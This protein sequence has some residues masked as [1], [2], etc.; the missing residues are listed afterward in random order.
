MSPFYFIVIFIDMK[1]RLIIT[2][3][4]LERLKKVITESTAHS[5]VVKQM[6]NELDNNYAPI[7]KFVREGGEYFEKAMIMIKA[8]EELI[9]PKAIFEYLK[10]KYKTGDDFT[11]QV[12]N[13][14]V[15]G[16][17]TDDYRLSKNVPMN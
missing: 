14:W 13:D 17:I 11:K 6:K 3:S 5:S 7:E 16:K 10:S 2:E 4:Q 12:I 1:K 9:T 8:D 15:H